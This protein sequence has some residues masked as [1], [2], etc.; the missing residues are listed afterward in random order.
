MI[1][2]GRNYP[3]VDEWSMRTGCSTSGP[4]GRTQFAPSGSR[5]ALILARRQ[6]TSA[7]RGC[8]ARPSSKAHGASTGLLGNDSPPV[9]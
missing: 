9:R 8:G 2:Y 3:D 1:P 5:L 7:D 4:R 6:Q